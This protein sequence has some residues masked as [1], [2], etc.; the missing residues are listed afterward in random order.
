M[1]YFHILIRFYSKNSEV[2]N[3]EAMVDCTDE[4]AVSTIVEAMRKNER[5][6]F[7]NHV[8]YPDLID[9][10]AIYQTEK[11]VNQLLEDKK[12]AGGIIIGNSISF[13]EPIRATDIVQQIENGAIG[14]RVT[15]QFLVKFPVKKENFE[16]KPTSTTASELIRYIS[17][18]GIDEKWMSCTCALQ[19]QEVAIIMVAKK[20][21]IDIDKKSVEKI[22][23]KPQNSDFSFS[24]QYE[25]F[26]KEVQRLYKIEM[27]LMATSL[28]RMRVA[29][30]HE[31]YN[32][33]DEEKDAIV[34]FTTGLL[35][36]LKKVCET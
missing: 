22:L 6:I 1:Q 14:Q 10:F 11:T 26:A 27:P 16:E 36:R 20:K 34:S 2:G 35:K 7:K 17:F 12:K 24:N 8:V 4:K 25:A 5:F 30:L 15:S 13:I 19:L 9:T 21:G 31:G 33:K 18:L 28:R 3:K 29:V 32:P 23:N